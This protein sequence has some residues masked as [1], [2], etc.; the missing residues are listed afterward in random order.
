[1]KNRLVVS[2]AAPAVTAGTAKAADA[3]QD[4]V[5]IKATH[6]DVWH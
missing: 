4:A 5:V 3:P 1:M 2:V 6:S